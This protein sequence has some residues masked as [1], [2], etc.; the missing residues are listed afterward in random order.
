MFVVAVFPS[1]AM[2]ATIINVPNAAVSA[3]SF[4]FAARDF[5]VTNA[6]PTFATI[7]EHMTARAMMCLLVL[8]TNA[9]GDIYAWI[10]TVHFV[11]LVKT[12]IALNALVW[13][14]F[15]N[16][17]AFINVS[18]AAPPVVII[19]ISLF[20]ITATCMKLLQLKGMNVLGVKLK[21]ATIAPKIS[22]QNQVA[23]RF[24]SAASLNVVIANVLF[25]R[26]VLITSKCAPV[27]DLTP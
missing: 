19:A 7:V 2:N 1:H 5:C 23:H 20:A 10:A 18:S 25:A 22:V 16:V 11:N 4:L 9:A 13:D 3:E 15:T 6:F 12:T 27:A 8:F 24:A 17:A 14:I 21:F 26:A